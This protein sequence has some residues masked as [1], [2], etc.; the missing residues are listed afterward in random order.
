MQISTR[1][2]LAW[3]SVSQGGLFIIQFGG[4]VAMARL[5]KPYEMGVYAVAAAIIGV[6]GTIRA[7]GLSSLIIRKAELDDH[8]TTTTFTINAL[9]AILTSLM[10]FVLALAGGALL[11]DP[12]VQHVMLLLAVTPLI[13]MFEF[14]PSTCLER[15]GAFRVLAVIAMIKAVLSTIVT[16]TLA[17]E[18]FSYMSIAWGNLVSASVS[19]V[20]IN[21]VGRRHASLRV[22][23]RDWRSVTVYGLQMLGVSALGNIAGRLSELLLGRL[24][25]ISALGLYTRASGLNG[26]LWDNLHLVIGRVTFVDFAEQRRRSIPLRESYLKIVAM[27]TGL[28]WPAFAGMA[29]LAGPVVATVYGKDWLGAATPLSMLSVAGLLLTTITMTFEIFVICGETNRQ[30]RLEARRT[31]VGLGLFGLGCLSGLVWAAASKIGEAIYMILLYKQDLKRMTETSAGDYR[32]IYR[33]SAGLTII[34]CAP[35]AVVMA[36]NGWSPDTSLISIFGAIAVG[37]AGW[38]AMLWKLHH[39]LFGEGEAIARRLFR[40]TVRSSAG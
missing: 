35:T 7:F 29:L 6:L 34:A 11:G 38:V 26:L 37:A 23:L 39:P 3:M 17:V 24:I 5:L 33:Q 12:G 18:G 16:I 2:N 40:I 21:V 27:I 22:G 20:C 25:S 1:R 28:L 15:G 32:S 14:L 10:I 30:L 8:L 13:N 4:S 19:V 36:A 9:L 31:L